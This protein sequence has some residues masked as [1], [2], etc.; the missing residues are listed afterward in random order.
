M[1]NKVIY[2]VII[3]LIICVVP[4]KTN[5]SS[6]LE[7]LIKDGDD[8]LNQVDDDK[9]V[10]EEKQLKSVSDDIYSVIFIVGMAIAVIFG[11]GLGIKFMLS[12][13]EEKAKVKEIL[14]IYVIG[15]VVLFGSFTI[16]KIVV[17]ILES[18]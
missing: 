9:I 1:K 16:W 4:I 14:V 17:N 8:F 10:I 6:A 7:D 13:I 11:I 12:S 2:I 15:C 18:A 3:V 5:A